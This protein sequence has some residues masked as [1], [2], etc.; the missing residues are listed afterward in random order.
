M[1][2]TRRDILE[3]AFALVGDAIVVACDGLVEDVNPAFERLGGRQREACI[4]RPIGELRTLGDAPSLLHVDGTRVPVSVEQ[5]PIGERVLEVLRDHRDAR[6]R[7]E[8][9]ARARTI[10]ELASDYHYAADIGENGAFS[11]RWI[12]DSYTRITGW[13]Q[14]EMRQHREGLDFVVPEDVPILVAKGMRTLAGEPASA[15]Y[16]IRTKSA[17]QRWVRDFTMPI[18]NEHGRVCALVG[19]AKDITE[20][21]EAELRVRESESRYRLLAEHSHDVI[22]RIDG[23]GVC[24]YVSPSV[25]RVLGYEPA[26]LVGRV[27]FALS[28]P[29]ERGPRE[30]RFAQSLSTGELAPMLVTRVRH[31]DGHYVHLETVSHLVRDDQ[32][33]LLEIQSSARDVSARVEAEEAL[34]RGEKRFRELL[35]ALPDPVIVHREGRVILANPAVV[36]LLGYE[37]ADQLVGRQAVDLVHPEDRPYVESRLAAK[38]RSNRAREHRLLARDGTPI[39]I[40]VSSVPFLFEGRLASIA[41]VHDRRAQKRIEAELALAE[42]LASL[43][44]VA[45]AVGHEIN[46]PLT[47]VLGALELLDRHVAALAN[48]PRASQLAA[49]VSVVREGAERVRDIVRDLKSL[50]LPDET[51]TTTSCCDLRRVLDVAAATAAHEIRHRARLVIEQDETLCVAGTEGRLVQVF[52][53]LLVNAAQ[54]IPDGDVDGNEIR[55]VARRAGATAVIEIHDTGAGLAEGDALRIFEP[56]FTTK[57]RSTGTGLGLAIVQRI[58]AS[59]GGSISAARRA[60]RGS[61]FRLTLPVR[62]ASA[63]VADASNATAAR[64]ARVLIADDEVFIGRIA[65][66]LLEPHEVVTVGADAT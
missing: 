59:V 7:R 28:H 5:H 13:T 8:L 57:P 39:E 29:D 19:A 2:D 6:A 56:F 37:R 27:G 25:Q 38:V 65:S 60:P 12:T 3:R 42:R 15:E 31:K 43:G 18:R 40:E 63:T 45:S 22:S 47:Y 4:G 61:T 23:R 34:A 1:S 48:E 33:Q 66:Q 55:V 54:A 30:Q 32:G 44:R 50:S 35:H 10:A 26:E 53:N 46:N 41:F 20:E 52:V 49:E 11:L 62:A 58:V 64:R 14:S 17:G 24:T 36:E 51:A 9:D 21:K 16:R